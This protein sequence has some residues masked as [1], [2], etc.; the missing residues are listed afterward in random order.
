M[1]RF[2]NAVNLFYKLVCL[3]DETGSVFFNASLKVISLIYR[4]LPDI[5]ACCVI[6][7]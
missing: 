6:C 1:F 5:K 2:E 7:L 4:Y 3:S